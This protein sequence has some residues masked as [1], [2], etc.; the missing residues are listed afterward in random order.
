MAYGTGH[1]LADGELAWLLVRRGAGASACRDRGAHSISCYSRRMWPFAKSVLLGSLAGAAPM[2]VFTVALAIGSLPEG[3]DGGG[4]LLPLFWF[5]IL[6]L[7]VSF[8]LVLGASIFVGLPLT[9]VLKRKGW[10]SG[11][12]YIASGAAVGFAIPLVI[13]SLDKA[14][15]EAGLWTA[16]LGSIGGGVTGRTWWVFGRE[17]YVGYVD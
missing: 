13:L 2:L 12:A 3:L 17:P 1:L 8:P 10:E 5:A 7:I 11:A 6:P 15:A 14:D 4:R 9:A 16:L